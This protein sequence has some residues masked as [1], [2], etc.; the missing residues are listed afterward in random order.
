MSSVHDVA[1]GIHR[2]ART[3]GLEP[4]LNLLQREERDLPVIEDTDKIRWLMLASEIDKHNTSLRFGPDGVLDDTNAA[5]HRNAGQ[6]IV[7]RPTL[8]QSYDIL[9][10][11][12]AAGG[13]TF[14]QTDRMFGGG[15][16]TDGAGIINIQSDEFKIQEY[17]AAFWFKGVE[18]LS[19]AP[20]II[21]GTYND[22]Q[23]I[24]LLIG[25]NRSDV[26]TL[27]VH[28]DY[29]NRQ[30][31]HVKVGLDHNT[32]HHIVITAKDDE[33]QIYIDGVAVIQLTQNTIDITNNI[34]TFFGRREQSGR[35][36]AGTRMAWFSFC[37]GYADQDWVTNDYAGK[38]DFSDDSPVEEITTIPFDGDL[39]PRPNAF[40]GL[41]Y[42]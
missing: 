1:Q 21:L 22:Q 28:F 16:Q 23:A 12:S 7:Q 13:F 11:D 30:F 38:R 26:D 10:D 15:V 14:P 8:S 18:G 25:Y 39:I 33:Q 29:A 41:M 9:H 4:L 37:K 40:S 34:M 3:I 24:N 19:N 42:G 27:D 17:T 32:W 20:L 5:V 6:Y 35:V 36:K 2:N 31:A